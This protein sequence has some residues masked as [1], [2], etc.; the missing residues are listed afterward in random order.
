MIS[1][2]KRSAPQIVSSLTQFW[3]STKENVQYVLHHQGS[4]INM[5]KEPVFLLV[6]TT[7][8]VQRFDVTTVHQ[9]I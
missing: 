6:Y 1:Q 8:S 9:R 2:E 7:K 3:F 5:R 4:P